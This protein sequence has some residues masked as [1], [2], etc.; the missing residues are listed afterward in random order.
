MSDINDGTGVQT[1]TVTGDDNDTRIDKWF[2]RHFPGLGKTMLYKLMR[3]GQVR[4]NGGRV[5]P[6]TR[7]FAGYEVR[8][9]PMPAEAY[10]PKV[11]VE[12]PLTS[13]ERAKKRAALQKIT[14]YEDRDVLVLNKPFGLATQ[15][16]SKV[17]RHVDGMIAILETD[18]VKP[19]LV[20]R[21][22]RETSGVLMVA[23]NAAAARALGRSLKSRD[24]QKF[25]WALVAPTPQMNDGIIE[26][27]IAKGPARGG[28][29]MMVNDEEGKYSKTEFW[30][31]EKA[32]RKAAWLLMKPETGRTHQL[33]VHAQLMGSH[34]IGDSKYGP[35]EPLEI[36][37]LSHA[38]KLHLH[39]R[40]VICPHP[41][42]RD[43][44]DVTAPLP[45]HMAESFT[46]FG[47][48]ENVAEGFYEDAK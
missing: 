38:D 18:K 6:D 4:L 35:E 39:A 23:K 10:Q 30:I 20:H 14:L 13:E 12:R 44:I 29:Y 26:A 36:E 31:V 9:P 34:I 11:V 16:G 27:R 40:R 5:K 42:G 48:D 28:E 32:F 25:Y 43:V 22:D 24:V 7:V 1:L 47:F 21:L 8:V 15:G 46:Y 17:K 33:R 41:N 19:K 3:K 37:D 2:W 45:P